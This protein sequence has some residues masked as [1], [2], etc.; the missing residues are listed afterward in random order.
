MQNITRKNSLFLLI[1]I[2]VISSCSNKEFDTTEEI[3][4]FISEEDNGYCYKMEV[5]GVS[6][7]LQYKPTDLM[8]QQELNGKLNE[9]E[10]VRLRNKYSKNLY[11]NLSMSIQGKEL[12]SNTAIDRNKFNQLVNDLV[13]NM[14]E[15]VS[16]LSAKKDTLSIID[17]I[18][19]RMYGMSNSTTIL[20]IYPR[21]KEILKEEYIYF[22]VQDLGLNTGEIKFKIPTKQLNKEPKLNFKN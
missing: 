13:F 16:L 7:T 22:I 10:I 8:V 20:I 6:Y 18:Y 1:L 3:F 2:L 14:P 19:P 21:D 4:A 9:P 5:N 11:F 12:L 15:K 17:C